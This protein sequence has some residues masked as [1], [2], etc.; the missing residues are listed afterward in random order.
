MKK[1]I[2]SFST[3]L[4]CTLSLSAQTFSDYDIGTPVLQ[5]IY[6][7]AIHG[8]DNN[9][10]NSSAQ[11]LQTISG[12]WAMVPPGTLTATG[13]RINLLPG[14][15]PCEGDCI[16]FFSDRT[17][18]FNFPIIL[19]AANGV[20]TVTLPGGLNLLNVHYFYLINLTLWAGEEAGAA[21]GN[22]V[23]HVESGD[24]ILMRNLI[25][26]GTVNCIDDTCNSMQEVLKINQSQ[27][28]YL[29]NCDLSGTFQTV[30]DYF[31]VQYGHIRNCKIHRSGGRCMYL[32]GGSA[33]FLIDGNECYDCRE[34]GIQA[35]E[36]SNFA[37]MRSP[38]LHYES[39]DIK[40]VNNVVH[41]I[42]G[43]GLGVV[44]SYNVLM[45]YNTLYRI[46]LDT[47]WG[48]TW[49]LF[50]LIHGGR[51]CYPATEFGGDSGTR[52]RCQSL[53][54]LGGWGT[55]SL[56]HDGDSSGF[57]IPNKNVFIYNNIFYN[58]PG[59]GTHYV[60][61]TADGAINLPA[62]SQNIPDPSRTDDDVVIKG[63]IVWNHPQEYSG[64]VGTTDG[65]SPSCQPV[66]S[67]D[68][69]SIISVNHINTI[70]PQLVDAGNGN[71]HPVNAG[72]VFSGVTYPIPSF[73]WTD[74]PASPAVPAGTLTNMIS[75]D[76][77]N[78]TRTGSSIAG[79]FASSYSSASP[80]ENRNLFY[81]RISPNPFTNSTTL[82]IIP[83]GGRT[84]TGCELRIYDLFGREVSKYEI[85]NQKTEISRNNLPGGMYLYQLKDNKQSISSGKLIVQ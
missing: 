20:G 24:H 75:R 58:P 82:Q 70:E 77:D 68:S 14:T 10:G 17:G 79:A 43:A 53:L 54:S 47:D 5:E 76:F 3:L 7:D 45:A 32:K 62:Y 52:A 80:I 56:D 48:G 15:Y 11:A 44:G 18:T 38:W 25:I 49:S 78:N 8:N 50:Q 69:N 42:Y 35:G 2:F 46:G 31:S 1:I 73:S 85:R 65:S 74:A 6:V 27:Y 40:V 67:C 64:M 37:F 16:N 63:N 23:L 66:S 28:I 71:F 19:Q 33:Y 29:E 13:Y 9:S 57:W 4:F 83:Q 30:L 34:A 55:S 60:H 81:V 36:S 72:N 84:I 39:Y 26:R 21:F 61:F 51:G 59:T 41:D 12:A 22:N